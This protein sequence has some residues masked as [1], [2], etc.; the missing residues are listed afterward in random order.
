MIWSSTLRTHTAITAIV[1]GLL[2][3]TGCVPGSEAPDATPASET[4]TPPVLEAVSP[5]AP[6]NPT[7]ITPP[8][9]HPV[10]TPVSI[11]ITVNGQPVAGALQNNAASAS[12]LTQLPLELA[13]TDYGSQEKIARIP[14]ALSLEGMPP[15]GSAEPGTIGYYAPDQALVLYYDAVSYYDG[16][17]PIG[18]FDDVDTVR[19]AP[20]F[21]GTITPSAAT[22][23]APA[24]GAE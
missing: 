13:F 8:T 19:D 7:L 4:R 15:G 6:S 2:A 24:N 17:I 10:S 9:E 20:A 16:I 23:A 21:T 11:T 14:T 22:G 3:L 1:V 5:T 12:L 18:T